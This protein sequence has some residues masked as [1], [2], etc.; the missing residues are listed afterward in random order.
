M[1]DKMKRCQEQF[2]AIPEALQ[3]QIWIRLGFALAFVLLFL[4]ALVLLL[5]WMS[6]IPFIALTIYS[7]ISAWILFRRVVAGDYVALEGHC[8]ETTVTSVRKRTKSILLQTE[9]H[10]VRVMIRQRLKRISQGASIKLYVSSST[11]V[12]DKDGVWLVPAYLAIEV[13][14]EKNTHDKS[15][16]AAS[17]TQGNREPDSAQGE[18]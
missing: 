3:K 6:A 7:V 18:P 9:E 12:Y 17:K 1:K 5:D 16:G 11:Q 10:A 14:G 15:Q 2:A 13:K 8:I 4:F